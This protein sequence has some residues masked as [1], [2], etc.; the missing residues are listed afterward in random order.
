MCGVKKPLAVC[1]SD[2]SH[3][4]CENTVMLVVQCILTITLKNIKHPNFIL[5]CTK[6]MGH[7]LL[8]FEYVGNIPLDSVCVHFNRNVLCRTV[9]TT[10]L[11]IMCRHTTL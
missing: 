8:Y 7:F 9:G 4:L 10:A 5:V 1:Q 2:Y 11:I 6:S 3:F